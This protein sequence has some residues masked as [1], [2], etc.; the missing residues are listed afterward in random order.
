MLVVAKEN[1]PILINN[2]EH[3]NFVE[4]DKIIPK[5]T[6][7]EGNFTNIKGL[8]RGNEFTYRLFIDNDGIIVYKKNVE[9]MMKSNADGEARVISMP[10]VKSR[11]MSTALIS[12][13]AGVIAFAVAKRMQKTN[14]QAFMVAGITA[15]IG[16]GLATYMRNSDPVVY[17]NQ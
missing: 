4:T 7:L 12:A 10:S 16:Y 11:T 5:G 3:K 13:G 14:K 2:D 8:R 17:S 6:I 1:S 15:L 9:P